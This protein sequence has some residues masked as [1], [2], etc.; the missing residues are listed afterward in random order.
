MGAD[1]SQSTVPLVP[2]A[3][4]GTMHS[5]V[6][7]SNC[8]WKRPTI[9]GPGGQPLVASRSCVGLPAFRKPLRGRNSKTW[10]VPSWN[11]MANSA[12]VIPPSS[13]GLQTN[14]R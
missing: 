4:S 7:E 9:I 6:A 11:S 3:E 1:G 12:A 5:R 14:Q 10:P 13:S 2:W 8:T